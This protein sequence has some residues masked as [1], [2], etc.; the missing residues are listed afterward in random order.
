MLSSRVLD[1]FKTVDPLLLSIISNRNSAVFSYINTKLHADNYFHKL[2]Q[3]IISQQLAGKAAEAIFAR[4][5]NLFPDQEISA[6][7]LTEMPEQVLRDIGA[8]WAKARYVKDLAAK[9]V[10]GVIRYEALAQLSDEEVIAELTQVKGV[11]RWTAEM[12]LI[13]TLGREDVFSLGDLGLKNAFKKLYQVEEK[14]VVKKMSEASI[15]WS[16]YRTYAS[17][18]LWSYLDNRS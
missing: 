12:F 14:D 15:A 10:A 8:S 9:T 18:A 17:L 11:G 5:L 4:F 7:L 13:F 16:P 3:A 1:H 6:Q 2:C